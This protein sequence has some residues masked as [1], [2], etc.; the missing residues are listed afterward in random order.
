MGGEFGDEKSPS[1]KW[2]GKKQGTVVAKRRVIRYQ[3][4][5]YSGI[6]FHLS[7]RT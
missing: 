2:S 1:K 4:V 5:E 3:G 7:P 6:V